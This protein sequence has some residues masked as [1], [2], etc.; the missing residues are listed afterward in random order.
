MQPRTIF[1]PTKTDADD[2]SLPAETSFNYTYIFCG[3]KMIQFYLHSHRIP[4]SATITDTHV[5][6]LEPHICIHYSRH[7]LRCFVVARTKRR[8][9]ALNQR[10]QWHTTH[11][12]SRSACI[13][14]YDVCVKY[15][16]PKMLRGGSNCHTIS[17][18]REHCQARHLNW[19]VHVQCTC[20]MQAAAIFD[21]AYHEH[22]SRAIK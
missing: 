13:Y 8:G 11:I 1:L 20:M 2:H 17:S 15:I 14:I 5:L 4:Y 12:H 3:R 10:H 19:L 16:V 6:T 18:Y 7:S 21:V 9:M 22:D